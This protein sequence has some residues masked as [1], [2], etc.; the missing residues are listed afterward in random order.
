[1]MRLKY[2]Y[3]SF[4]ARHFY[5]FILTAFFTLFSSNSFSLSLTELIE[6]LY[7][8]DASIKSAEAAVEEANNDISTARA[9]FLPEFDAKFEEGYEEQ[10]KDEAANTDLE[11]NE[12][13]LT[14]KQKLWDF[15]DTSSDIRQK[16]NALDVAQ[17]DLHAAN[18]TLIIDAVDA[19]LGYI[20]AVKK[21][22]SEI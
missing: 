13:D 18:A 20:D 22:D 5:L 21:L 15:G 3:N 16:K 12:M 17:L 14:F 2:I 6:G 7:N 10:W 4:I 9:A 11:F 1:M 8:T 19:Y